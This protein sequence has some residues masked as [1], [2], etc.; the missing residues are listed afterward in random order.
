MADSIEIQH[1]SSISGSA[2]CV[3]V[4]KVG[5]LISLALLHEPSEFKVIGAKLKIS[6]Y[7]GG[8]EHVI[9]VEGRLVSGIQ[10]MSG[11]SIPPRVVFAIP[12]LYGLSLRGLRQSTFELSDV[13]VLGKPSVFDSYRFYS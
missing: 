7:P 13:H 4:D 3:H 8:G 10:S 11:G 5:I 9:D 1:E 12:D 6:A 2:D